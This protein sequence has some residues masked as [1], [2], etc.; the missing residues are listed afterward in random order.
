MTQNSRSLVRRCGR[1]TVRPENGQLLTQRQV[2]ER[3]GPVST[4]EQNER[5]KQSDERD[6]RALCCRPINL[7]STGRLAIRFWRPTHGP[8]TRAEWTRSPVLDARPLPG[9]SRCGYHLL[10]AHGVQILSERG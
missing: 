7:K 3:D 1:L 9:R 4:T 6:Q 5:S 8:S 10:D 2:L